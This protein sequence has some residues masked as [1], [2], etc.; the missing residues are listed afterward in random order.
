MWACYH[1][2]LQLTAMIYDQ[3]QTEALHCV[4]DLVPSD[5]RSLSSGKTVLRFLF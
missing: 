5:S 1:I 4:R 3:S 2:Q